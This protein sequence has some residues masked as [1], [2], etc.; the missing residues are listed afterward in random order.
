MF[1]RVLLFLEDTM[2]DP[3]SKCNKYPPVA[4]ACPCG[5]VK[6]DRCDTL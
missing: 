2:N 6:D 5:V 3:Y 4:R 1:L